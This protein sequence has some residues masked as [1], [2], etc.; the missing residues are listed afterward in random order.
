MQANFD[1]G[2]SFFL[3]RNSD[4]ALLGAVNLGNIQRG[5]SQSTS[6]GYW[7]G[8]PFARKGYMN[9]AIELLL[10]TIFGEFGLHR[11]EAATLPNN[12]ASRN[13]LE[14]LGFK[15]EGKAREY[16]KINGIWSDH[17]IYSLTESDFKKY[18]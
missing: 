4:K 9:E 10:P 6:I 18:K 7:I 13:L 12:N 3:F 2:Y 8:Y 16:L 17:I 14:K 1:K 5:V 11:I 15:Q